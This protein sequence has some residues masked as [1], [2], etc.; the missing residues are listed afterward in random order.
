MLWVCREDLSSKRFV[1][2]L[3]N[4]PSLSGFCRITT[5]VAVTVN[6]FFEISL[7]SH[8]QVIEE[9]NIEHVRRERR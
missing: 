4:R 7:M 2:Q 9:E 5:F 8:I 3:E 1:R 6:K